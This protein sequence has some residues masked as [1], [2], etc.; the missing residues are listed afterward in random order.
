MVR[1]L[2]A[3]PLFHQ[4]AFAVDDKGRT[5]NAP[6]FFA[7]HT[8]C[9]HDVEEQ[10]QRFVWIGNQFKRQ[11]QLCF[12]AFMRTHRIA[13]G[14]AHHRIDTCEIGMQITEIDGFGGAARRVVLRIKIQHNRFVAVVRKAE[15]A[16]AGHVGLKVG[17]QHVQCRQRRCRGC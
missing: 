2:R 9:L 1:H 12:K 4:P 14:T 11:V 13:A 15:G 17:Y 7:V 16:A 6:D 10:A 8:F 5:L 3:A